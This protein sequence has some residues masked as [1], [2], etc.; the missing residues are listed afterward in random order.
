M[1]Y[2]QLIKQ[3]PEEGAKRLVAEFGDRLFAV[4]YKVCLNTADAED[5]VYRTLMRAI[6]KIDSFEGNSSFY[7]WLYAI[8]MNFRRM[9]VRSLQS[10]RLVFGEKL[11]DVQDDRLDP[12]ETLAQK[13]DAGFLRKAV[14]ELPED[15]RSV[16]VFRYFEDLPLVEIARLLKLPPGTVRF[17]L[18]TAKRLIRQ[19]I[20]KHLSG[21]L[22]LK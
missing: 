22:H 8:L 17:R 4:A 14:S 15:L 6:E 1:D 5:L 20:G 13:V 18:F 3:D 16:V 10:D 7:T 12:V 19:K 21:E 2:L 11:P 9:D